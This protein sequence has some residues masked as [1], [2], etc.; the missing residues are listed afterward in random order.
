MSISKLAHVSIRTT[1]VEAVKHFYIRVLGLR[2]GFRPPFQFPGAWLYQGSDESEFGLVHIIG[3]DARDPSGLV[4]YLG[5]KP[6]DSLRGSGAVDHLA[7]QATDLAGMR[8]RLRTERLP[9]QE[10]TVPNLGLHQLFV[11]DPSGVT[12]ELNYAAAEAAA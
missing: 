10:R 6:M 1:D 2:E 11:V 8:E 4:A 12:I 7:F 5:D 9:Y 3:I